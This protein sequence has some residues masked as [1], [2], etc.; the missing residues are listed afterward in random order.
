MTTEPKAKKEPESATYKT[1][2]TEV[3]QIAKEV[4]DPELDLDVMVSK[5]ERGYTLVKAMR[6]RLD[7]TRTRIDEL[8]G[9]F[10]SSSQRPIPENQ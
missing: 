1:M 5:I 9:E 6:T 3:E 10:E 4:S 7:Q 2:L 8:R